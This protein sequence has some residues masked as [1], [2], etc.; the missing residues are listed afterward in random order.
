MFR[1]L[2]Q[3]LKFGV[4]MLFK[5]PGFTAVAVFTLA[6]GIGAN[7]AIF[8]V[9]NAF[10]IKPLP[11]SNLSRLAAVCIGQKAP[12][13]AADY[14]DWKSQNH[15]F[16][17]LA[18]Y[19][20]SNVNL[21]GTAEPER[22]F[23]A[24]VTANFFDLLE[25]RPSL[26][27]TFVSGEDQPGH[28]QVALISYGL[29]QRRFGAAPNIVG[30]SVNLDGRP[31]NIIG[32]TSAD[33]NFP[34]PTDVWTPLA[35]TPL[36]KSDRAVRNLKVFGRM[37]QGVTLAQAQAEISTISRQL[38]QAYPATNKDRRSHVMQLAEFVEGTILIRAMIILLAMVGVVLLI[39][40]ANIANLQ[41]A[42]G[43]ARKR[44]IAV[45]AALGA[46]RWRV[47]RMLLAENIL[48]ALTG[49]IASILFAGYCLGLLL[50]SMPAE[51]TR[52]I[53]GWDR[54]ALDGQALA[55]TLGIT[56][57]S[58]ILA[59]LMPALGI[60]R[61]DLNESLKESSRGAT[62]G[63]SRQRLRSIFVV[64]QIGVAMILLVL[65]SLFVGGFRELL[66]SG[67]QF[68]PD[69]VLILAVNLPQSRYADAPARA[70]FY[71]DALDRLGSIPG[72][73]SR[74]AFTTFPISNNGTTSDYFQIEGTPAPDLQHGPWAIT[75]AI[76]PD[77]TALFHIPM[78][79]GRALTAED[80][81][82]AQPVALISQ[83]LA[84]R[85]WPQESALGKRIRIGRPDSSSP[86][87]E[88]V[89]VTGNVL[90]DWTDNLP[91]AV[92][93]RPVAQAPAA[94]TFFAIRGTGDPN[95]FS[96]PAAEQL[97]KIDPLLPAF[98]VM[99]LSDAISEQ[100]SGNAQI[101][102]MVAILG[103][104]ALVIAVVGVYGIVAFAVA[105]RM[106]E[107][108]IRM[109]MGAERRHIFALVIR[110]G[111]LLAAAGLGIG[112]PSA[113]AL[114]RLTN[115][116]LYGSGPTNPLI[117]AGVA[118]ILAGAALAASYVP[119][120]RAT[121]ADPLEALRYE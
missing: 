113:I 47:V 77:F 70:R 2:V 11:F 36:Q 8:S 101:A 66:H 115:S 63:G 78:V 62:A 80:H 95:T 38:E 50:R 74:A 93:Y 65:A 99:S 28:E 67:D 34:A 118:A 87:L 58:G 21:T 32:V 7:T 112:I 90:F 44:E 14:F 9:A 10:L 1:G 72:A 54:I 98:S 117:F 42:R 120:R 46:S 116:G 107:F 91:E 33:L 57:V 60:S 4:R 20:Q 119:A 52:L 111:A 81:E 22:V 39:V 86:W 45:R 61:P 43:G 108:G 109:A 5:N 100:L 121:K 53:P 24:R 76:S 31:F 26:G 59:G 97:A 69:H 15:S 27:R 56:L 94:E 110:R 37:K 16:D 3:D 18:A 84:E 85:Y 96:K 68:D 103:M 48:L 92:I 105:E 55:F 17:D 49:G 83:R 29:W 35:L 40:C 88:I 102:G 73:Q 25:V 30:Q 19:Q 41:L 114:A 71:R 23:G 75:Q 89:G 82:G 104:I 6:L 51:I 79:A 106:H 13:A 12:S 64:A